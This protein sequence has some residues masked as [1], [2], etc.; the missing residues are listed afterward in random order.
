MPT[1]TPPE[2]YL[3]LNQLAA[4]VGVSYPTALKL[5]TEEVIK[6]D[7]TT[8]R[9]ALFKESRV[10]ELRSTIRQS[11]RSYGFGYF[12]WKQRSELGP[13]ATW[14]G[15]LGGANPAAH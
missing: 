4:R 1:S 7:A 5:V 3:S 12:G 11:V 2:S 13:D 10:E 6:P 14:Q 8:G 15:N 9:M